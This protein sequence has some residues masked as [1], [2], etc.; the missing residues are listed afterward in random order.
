M[1]SSAAFQTPMLPSPALNLASIFQTA[2][3][4]MFW[5]HGRV[6]KTSDA[7]YKDMQDK[8]AA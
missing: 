4:L 1:A 3:A 7:A 2:R 5:L 6:G 8:F